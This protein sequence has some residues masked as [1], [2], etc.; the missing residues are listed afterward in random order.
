MTSTLKPIF[1]IRFCIYVLQHFGPDV[2]HDFEP[3]SKLSLKPDYEHTPWNRY[4]I[5]SLLES[6]RQLDFEDKFK[7][8][9]DLYFETNTDSNVEFNFGPDFKLEFELDF[10]LDAKS[11]F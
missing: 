4:W 9:Y 6:D 1:S 3:N 8:N 10:E 5:L 11:N 7:A 2:E